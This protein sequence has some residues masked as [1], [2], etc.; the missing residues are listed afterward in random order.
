[1]A[2]R[3][4]CPECRNVIPADVTFCPECGCAVKKGVAAAPRPPGGLPFIAVPMLEVTRAI[5]GRLLVGAAMFWTGVE[6]DAPPAVILALTVWGSA[7]PLY[8][9]ARHAHKL[10]AL[11]G[12]RELEAAVRKQ[13]AAARE[14]AERQLANVDANTGR[15][16]ELEERIDFLER[17]V[18]RER[19]HR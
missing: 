17:L 7:V 9:R 3:I 8:L 1:V 15:I 6:F 4:E 18:A 5:V 10:G 19:E 16:A 12:Q 13:L 2:A 11:A 14:E